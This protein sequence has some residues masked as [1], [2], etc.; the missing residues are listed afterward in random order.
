MLFFFS[1]NLSASHQLDWTPLPYVQSR[2]RGREKRD[3]IS[4][5][6]CF[7]KDTKRP[8]QLNGYLKKRKN[9]LSCLHDGIEVW[10]KDFELYYLFFFIFILET[11]TLSMAFNSM[12]IKNHLLDSSLSHAFEYIQEN[13]PKNQ[14]LMMLLNHCPVCSSLGDKT[15]KPHNTHQQCN[16]CNRIDAHYFENFHIK[17]L[18]KF[19]AVSWMRYSNWKTIFNHFHL[20][21]I[22][23]FKLIH[24]I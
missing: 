8:Q 14:R 11:P 4:Q 12:I 24:S 9:D 10:K 1:F 17:E 15:N 13:G 18:R 19:S 5:W 2:E 6:F 7:K 23:R 16:S 22:H 21:S 3:Y 20:I